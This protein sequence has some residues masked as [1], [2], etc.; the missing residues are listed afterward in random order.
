MLVYSEIDPLLNADPAD[1]GRRQGDQ[2]GA[3][4]LPHQRSGLPDAPPPAPAITTGDNVLLRF[5]NA[6]LD[7]VMPTLGGGLYM[8]LKAEDGNRY[9]HP[10]QQYGLELQAGK[11]IDAMIQV[12]NPGTY[13]IY[14]RSDHTTN[15][16]ASGGGML[17][18]LEAAAGAGL[19]Q[20]SAA[21]YSVAEN[22]G[23]VTVT[24]DRVGGSAGAVSVDFATADGS[25]T[26]AGLDYTA[27][28]GTLN[29]DRR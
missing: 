22:G 15:G 19:L 2:L 25:A 12:T 1:H 24:V 20:F 14:D 18:N 9:P 23:T 27:A 7:S 5:V 8:D 3:A 17:V 11:T 16:A 6:G 4:V 10:I 28:L 26:T 29:L 13:A 21:T